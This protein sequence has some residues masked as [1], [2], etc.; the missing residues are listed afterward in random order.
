MLLFSYLHKMCFKL[1]GVFINCSFKEVAND[2]QRELLSYQER[3]KVI[4]QHKELTWK[5]YYLYE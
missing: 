2:R 3:E 5:K 4:R 1:L